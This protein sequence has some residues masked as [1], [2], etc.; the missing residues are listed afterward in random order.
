MRRIAVLIFNVLMIAAMSASPAAAQ[1]GSVDDQ[2][3]NRSNITDV[4][5]QLTRDW[6]E[7]YQQSAVE[8]V[9]TPGMLTARG[10]VV[11]SSKAEVT[12][13][14]SFSNL[15]T[16]VYPTRRLELNN[17][18]FQYS[19]PNGQPQLSAITL[20]MTGLDT[21][22]AY[23]AT[24]ERMVI[25]G[26]TMRSILE[27]KAE[28]DPKL[29]AVV[30]EIVGRPKGTENATWEPQQ[31]CSLITPTNV[32]DAITTWAE[33]EGFVKNTGLTAKETPRW[34]PATDWKVSNVRVSSSIPFQ[35]VICTAD[36][37]Y[38]AN[39]FGSPSLPMEIRGMSYK[40]WGND[41]GSK[42]W[43]ETHSWP[44]ASAQSDDANAFYR[45]WVVNGV[46]FQQAWDMKKKAMAASGAPR[47]LL[48]ALGQQNAEANAEGEAYLKKQGVDVDAIKRAEAEETRKYAE[49][50]RKSGGTWGYP[51]DK[52]GNNG[53]LGCYHPTGEK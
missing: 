4:A 49:P 31:Y 12:C 15:V 50:C 21:R 11:Q 26:K 6:G 1:S 36:V 47:N 40:L 38:T 8:Q 27:A 46:T 44:N 33:K 2:F 39:V 3:C 19:E 10:I 42:M 16:N 48:E 29:A 30:A 52:Y 43:L 23:L 32:S 35:H 18:D 22:G 9:A 25:D 34:H 41:D 53:R 14:I 7:R 51:T 5:A 28:T 17:V 37:S 45:A 20:P 24:W 13:R